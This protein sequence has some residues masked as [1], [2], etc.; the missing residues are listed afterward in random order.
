[1]TA[2]PSG[3]DHRQRQEAREDE[4]GDRRYPGTDCRFDQLIAKVVQFIRDQRSLVGDPVTDEM[5]HRPDTTDL[6]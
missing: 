5:Q 2:L 1:M 6:L 3:D 4:A